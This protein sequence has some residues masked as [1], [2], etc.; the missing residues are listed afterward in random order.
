VLGQVAGG[1]VVTTAPEL[2][3]TYRSIR[4]D[5]VAAMIALRNGTSERALI[6][7]MM[8]AHELRRNQVSAALDPVQLAFNLHRRGGSG[9][10]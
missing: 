7:R 5:H 4:D 10:Q 9:V 6:A 2:G 8:A 3:E 1:E